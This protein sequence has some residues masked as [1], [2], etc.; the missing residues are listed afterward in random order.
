[1]EEG[2][3]TLDKTLIDGSAL[4]K[5]HEMLVA[6]GVDKNNADVLCAKDS[7]VFSVMQQPASHQMPVRSEKTG[8]VTPVP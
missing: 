7:D 1:M 8:I 5:I 4:H 3:R 2:M 6:Q